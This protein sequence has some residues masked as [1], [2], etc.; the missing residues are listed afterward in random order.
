MTERA[1]RSLSRLPGAQEPAASTPPHGAAERPLE[2]LLRRPGDFSFVQAVRI[3]HQ[4]L[5]PG[6]SLIAFVQ[7]HLRIRPHLSL[8]FPPRDIF[9]LERLPPENGQPVFRLTVCMLSLYGAASPLPTF[10]TEDLLE[11]AREDRCAGRDF[12][13]IV[14]ASFFRNFL[15]S[16]WFRYNCM[17]A[18]LEQHDF[19]IVEAIAAFSGLADPVLRRRLPPSRRL[20]P[21]SGILSQYPRSAAGL[22]ALL[23]T[24][25]ETPVE[26]FPCIRHRAEVPTDQQARLLSQDQPTCPSGLGRDLVLGPSVQTRN[27]KLAIVIGP[28]E[29]EAFAALVPGQ[30]GYEALRLLVRFYCTEP[31]E[32]DLLLRLPARAAT[33]FLEATPLP[34]AQGTQQALPLR[35]G[36]SAWLGGA[37]DSEGHGSGEACCLHPG[38]GLPPL[39][40]GCLEAGFADCGT[41][42]ATRLCELDSQAA[43]GTPGR[44]STP[45]AAP[46]A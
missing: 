3:L 36:C 45:C 1:S 14:G 28:L 5:D 38:M 31:E 26:V 10:Y 6:L 7:R 17:Q 16:G 20:A 41:H 15:H 2:R 39:A 21:L 30:P 32:F 35:L 13:D 9:S 25:F 40:D 11:E 27:G 43:S 24:W 4:A 23:R 12:L 46:P 42:S 22:A 8:A 29:P 37:P 18:S 19:T 44:T 33:G 34:A